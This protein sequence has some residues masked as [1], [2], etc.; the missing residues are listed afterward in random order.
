M[1]DWAGHNYAYKPESSLQH[2]WNDWDNMSDPGTV[3]GVDRT[4]NDDLG[5]AADC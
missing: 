4:Q 1:S 2:F 3:Q 5:F